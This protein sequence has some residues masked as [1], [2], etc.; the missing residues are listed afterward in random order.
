MISSILKSPTAVFAACAAALNAAAP[1]WAAHGAEPADYV[2]PIIGASTSKKAAR[3]G[4]GLGKTFPGPATPF[5]L[6]QLSPDTMT[7]GDNGPGYSWHMST[8][9]G[10]SF[11]HMSGIGWFGDLGNFLVTPTTGPLR[12]SKGT[13]PKEDMEFGNDLHSAPIEGYRSKFSHDTETAR[14]GYY[15]VTLDDYG[16]RVELAAAPR[17]GIMRMTYPE[18]ENSRIQ[19]DLAR[20][21]GGTSAEQFVEVVDSRTIRGWMKCPPSN[22]GWGNGAGRA[23]YTVYFYCQFSKPLK[24]FGVWEAKIPEGVPR[25]MESNGSAAY[26]KILAEAEVR[27]MERSARGK[28]LG[29][30]TEFPTK[31]GEKVLLKSGIS[32]VGMENARENLL[33]DI[34]GWDFEK[35]AAD[36]RKLWNEALSCMKVE[37]AS[38]REKTIFYTAL[39]HAMIDPRSASDKNGEYVGA[40]RGVHRAEGFTYRTIFSGWDVFRSQFPLLTII[41]PDIVNDEINSLIQ[42][43]ELSGRGDFPR[44]E[45]MN[46]YSGCMLGDPAVSVLA[47]AY[48]KGIR[49]YD[50]D[51]A[52]KYAAKTNA[53]RDGDN[54]AYKKH[55]YVPGKVSHTLELAYSDWC[56][57]RLAEMTGREADAKKYLEGS[58]NYKNIWN[59]G[60]RWFTAKGADGK[61]LPFKGKTVHG[62][63]CV[64]S[65]NFQQGWFVP[66]DIEGFKKLAGEDFFESELESFFENTPEDFL[67][68]DYYNHPNEPNH[69]VPFM[70][71]RTGKP[72]LTQKWTRAICD[73]A[74]GTDVA[75][76]VG[77]DD[78]GQMSAWYVLAASG[79]HPI[80]PGNTRYEITS[81]VFDRVEIRLDKKYHKGSRFEIVARNN[82]PEN[83]YIQSVRLNGKDIGRRWIDHSEISAGGRLELQMGPRPNEK[84]GLGK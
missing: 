14:A 48:A 31:K 58:K 45:F 27:P 59:E 78:V 51:K 26:Q 34:P 33:S 21:I 62:Q 84:L 74:Y 76:I 47:D 44:W 54:R 38:D 46:A 2:N 10:F 15:A 17:A 80:C 39:Y 4:H 7:G 30:Y 9:E 57:F 41:R 73:K 67:W 18:S 79:L 50:A 56:M 16:I 36:A 61:W 43:A 24:K 69:Q 83:I 28:H 65:N 63:G 42:M 72:W 66:H 19:I 1:A 32:F 13:P 81:P 60:E 35:T 70:F 29:F 3:A 22:G 53:E 49:G 55:G 71:N 8:I 6:V 25:K 64:E 5:G 40:D 11:T 12:T 68:N 52:Y 23:D 82:S 37:G 75:G 77:N 20:R